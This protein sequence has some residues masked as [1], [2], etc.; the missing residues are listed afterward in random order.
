MYIPPKESEDDINMLGWAADY[1]MSAEFK[2]LTPEHQAL[3]LRHIRERS[4]RV[5][6][7]AGGQP[8]AQGGAPAGGAPGELPVV[9][10]GAQMDVA[11]SPAAM[12]Q[13]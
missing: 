3:I 12:L 1:R 10:G 9:P 5:A 11:A 8:G 4:Q 7:A 2:Y 13:R 6:Q